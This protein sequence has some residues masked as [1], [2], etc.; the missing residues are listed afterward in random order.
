MSGEHTPTQLPLP[1][2]LRAFYILALGSIIYLILR[3]GAN[4]LIPLTL[5]AL[6]SMLLTPLTGWL[7]KKH[8]GRL[9]GAALP[10]L[11]IIAF[12]FVLSGLAVRQIM[13]I[14]E[15]LA[16]AP[17]RLSES[18]RRVDDFLIWHLGLEESPMPEFEEERITMFLGE[19]SGE[20]LS[21]MGGF[22]GL[23]FGAIL[24]PAFTFFLLFYRHH[25]QGFVVRLFSRSPEHLV[26]QHTEEM[27]SVAQKYLV[28]VITVSA[29]LAV[30]NSTALFLIGV[31]HAIFFGV[32]AGLLNIV[33][34]FGPFFGAILP[35]L[36]VYLMRDSLLYPLV[37]VGA[38]IVIQLMESYFLT[39]KIIGSNVHLNPLVIFFGLLVGA[40]VWGVIGMIIIIP[41]LSI[42]MQFFKLSPMTEPFA[43][44]LGPSCKKPKA[45]EET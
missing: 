12:F 14:G 37:V 27:R 11:L 25:L 33:P 17:D 20:L 26:Q 30:L 24:I 3:L 38:F 10:V 28:G 16:D 8:L 31:E 29:I 40:L 34:F 42:V 19:Y 4:L 23:A 21:F 32:F 36:Y 39:P 7:E 45:G 9:L 41:V 5:A 43:F 2:Y 1:V 18:Y 15:S 35:V 22:A 13:H 44:L 6:L